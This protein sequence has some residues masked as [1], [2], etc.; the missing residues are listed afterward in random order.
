[1]IE[2]EFIN[3]NNDS[4]FTGYSGETYPNGKIKSLA[5]KRNGEV[6]D[7]L[8]YYHKN[9]K[10]ESKGL[11]KDRLKNGWWLY[12]RKDGTLKAKTEYVPK[13]DDVIYENQV[14]IFDKQGNLNAEESS[15]FEIL[16]PDT[17]R[18]GKNI[19]RVKNYVSD[20]DDDDVDDLLISVIIEN[21]YS[22]NEIKK[23]TFSDGTLKPFFGIIGFKKGKQIVKGI[24]EEK[25]LKTKE[26]KKDSSILMILN[27]Y[28]RFEKEVYVTDSK[29]SSELSKRLKEELEQE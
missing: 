1:M 26:I 17:I 29:E 23:D 19:A 9:G 10:V 14:L 6:I 13:G 3:S 7:T 15:Y 12:F 21:K 11:I 27:H 8:F 20:Y 5:Y 24:I 25:T 2:V 28:K 22:E 4:V 18:M 16:I